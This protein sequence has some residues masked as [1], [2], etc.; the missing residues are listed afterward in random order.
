MHFLIALLVLI[1]LEYSIYLIGSNI[2]DKTIKIIVPIILIIF[3]KNY[4][5]SKD[6]LTVICLYGLLFCCVF[7]LDNAGII[8]WLKYLLMFLILPIVLLKFPTG[9]HIPDI[10]IKILILLGII[11][12][13]QALILFFIIWLKIPIQP[14]IITIARYDNMAIASYG[15]LGYVNTIQS[16][17]AGI[18][19]SRSQGWFLEPSLL[20]SFLIYPVLVSLGYYL[21]SNKKRYFVA[22]VLCLCGLLST[23]SLAGFFGLLTGLLVLA[24]FRIIKDKRTGIIAIALSGLII[25]LLANSIMHSLNNYHTNP[26]G[27]G[28]KK[29]IARD[30]DGPSGNL[31]RENYNLPN[32]LRIIKDNPFGIGLGKTMEADS[33]F[34]S[35]NAIVFWFITG[36]LPA[37]LVLILLYLKLIFSY[38]LPLLRQRY[39]PY[40]FIAAS[41]IGV[42]V[43][44][45]SYGNWM[46]PYYLFIVALMILCYD[47]FRLSSQNNIHGIR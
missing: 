6:R 46:S 17:Y 30:P 3:F 22:A 5:L 16:P 36:G 47:D 9:K 45:L 31:F 35:A 24:I 41:F 19:I 14:E 33:E 20:A 2:I 43:H 38:C 1:I 32:Y 8:Q 27:S 13:I 39:W 40:S 29:I 44:N 34:I 25:L 28:V 15:I 26:E 4:R 42:T 23:F 7:H 11:F 37:V 10:L 18:L 21:S 12:S